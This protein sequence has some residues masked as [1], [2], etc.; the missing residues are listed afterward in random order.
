MNCRLILINSLIDELINYWGI[1]NGSQ[2]PPIFNSLEIFD[3]ERCRYM[4]KY[5]DCVNSGKGMSA[6]LF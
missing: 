1:I 3:I 4:D 6:V 2:L 5:K